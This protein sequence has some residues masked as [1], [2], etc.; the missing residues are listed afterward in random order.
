MNLR[1]RKLRAWMTLKSVTPK[2]V[3]SANGVSLRAV[4]RFIAGTMT[5][6]PLR[7]WFAK[8]GCPASYLPTARATAKT[9][10]R[11]RKAA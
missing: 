4:H 2:G 10:P 11:T 9:T 8:Q 1:T 3:A 5:S 7:S 6:A